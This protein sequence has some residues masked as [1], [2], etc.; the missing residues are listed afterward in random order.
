MSPSHFQR[1]P[2]RRPSVGAGSQPSDPIPGAAERILLEDG[3]Q[4]IRSLLE[5]RGFKYSTGSEAVSSAGPFAT[6]T[7]QRGSLQIGFIVRNG[8]ALGC[9]N[10]TDGHG[11]VGHTDL[12]WALGAE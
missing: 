8:D 12:A 11:Y 1:K 9:P 7:F 4:A 6:G 5:S 3:L 10:Y 2:Q